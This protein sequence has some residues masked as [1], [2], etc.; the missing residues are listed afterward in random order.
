MKFRYYRHHLNHQRPP[1]HCRVEN[2]RRRQNTLLTSL[3]Y[4]KQFQSHL[5]RLILR[6]NYNLQYFRQRHC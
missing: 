5:H 6:I 2:H 1:F 4:L 3:K